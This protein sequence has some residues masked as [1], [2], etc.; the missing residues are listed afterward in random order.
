VKNK[1]PTDCEHCSSNINGTICYLKLATHEQIQYRKVTISYKKG[2]NLFVEGHFPH[3]IFCVSKGN[4]KLTK[5]G[6]NGKESILKIATV[7]DTLGYK[8]LFTEEKY[9][10]TTTAM[11]DT[12]VCFLDKKLVMEIIEKNLSFSM[13]IIVKLS[14]DSKRDGE[15][16]ISLHHKNVRERLAEFM[17]SLISSHGMQDRNR[18]KINLQF[19]RTEL[20]TI[21]GTSN[22]TLNRLISEFKEMEILEQKGKILYIINEQ[23]LFKLSNSNF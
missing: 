3:G 5:H 4:I 23:E 21:I 14:H 13:N 18:I 20:S 8:S 17:H 22:E 2:Q 1:L 6:P 16:L 11:E 12:E 7:G 19:T 10:C 15:K 9:S